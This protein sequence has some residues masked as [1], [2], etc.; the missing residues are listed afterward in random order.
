MSEQNLNT[1]GVAQAEDTGTSKEESQGEQERSPEEEARYW[2]NK[3]KSLEDSV[4]AARRR[5]QE[6]KEEKEK[7]EKERLAQLEQWQQQQ[8]AEKQQQEFEKTFDTGFKAFVEENPEYSNVV[9]KDVIRTLVLNGSDVK[10]AI[11]TAYGNVTKS[12]KKDLLDV[13]KT[14]GANLDDQSAKQASEDRIAKAKSWLG[15]F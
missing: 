1:P 14:T 2:K 11:E 3:A 7:T 13:K 6:A 12:P 10:T 4:N 9:N 8:E 5:E 15:A